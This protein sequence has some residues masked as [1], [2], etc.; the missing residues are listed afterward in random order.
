MIKPGQQYR[1]RL[2]HDFDR[3]IEIVEMADHRGDIGGQRWLVRNV[4]GSC[5]KI[6]RR[7]KMRQ[8]TLLEAFELCKE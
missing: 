4:S 8:D 3:V 1:A 2:P 6:G 5:V 7:T